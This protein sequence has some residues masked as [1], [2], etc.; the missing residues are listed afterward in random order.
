M[1]VGYLFSSNELVFF[2][3]VE[4]SSIL[5]LAVTGLSSTKESRSALYFLISFGFLLRFFLMAD[6]LFR[7]KISLHAL[8][9]GVGVIGLS[10]ITFL[11]KLPIMGIHQWLP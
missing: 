11:A 6:V 9:V 5:I 3:S 8:Y 1:V 10:A 2:T 7:E 4:Y